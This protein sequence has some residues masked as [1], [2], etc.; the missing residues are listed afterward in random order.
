MALDGMDFDMAP[1]IDFL[2][3]DECADFFV[4]VTVNGDCK[5]WESNYDDNVAYRGIR[6]C[7]KGNGNSFNWHVDIIGDEDIGNGNVHSYDSNT[8]CWDPNGVDPSIF[9]P[10]LCGTDISNH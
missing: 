2:Q 4:V 9:Q 3:E 7:K 8:C 5:Y 1:H 10:H 6:V